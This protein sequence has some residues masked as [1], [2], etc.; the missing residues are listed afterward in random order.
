MEDSDSQLHD[1][2]VGVGGLV[3]IIHLHE[4][5]VLQALQRV[6]LNLHRLS[7][8]HAPCDQL[9]RQLLAGTFLYTPSHDAKP[10]PADSSYFISVTTLLHTLPHDVKLTPVSCLLRKSHHISDIVKVYQFA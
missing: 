7:S 8:H 5:W 2:D 9:G 10:T 4:V 6:E 3:Q 1:D